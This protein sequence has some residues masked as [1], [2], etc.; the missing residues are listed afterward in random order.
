[1]FL[2]ERSKIYA[3]F[4]D[5]ATW[6]VPEDADGS[7]KHGF[8]GLFEVSSSAAISTRL[9]GREARPE[10]DGNQSMI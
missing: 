2:L 1:M 6:N 8:H 5:L 3:G 9:A 7:R 4:C 10:E